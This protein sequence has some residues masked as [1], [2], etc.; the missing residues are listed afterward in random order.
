MATTLQ[1]VG[2]TARCGATVVEWICRWGK[3]LTI[4]TTPPWE[5]LK[6]MTF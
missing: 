3:S 4:N 5:Q 1:C 2:L 6:R